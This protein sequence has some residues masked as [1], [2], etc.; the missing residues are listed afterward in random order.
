MALRA[1]AQVVSEWRWRRGAPALAVARCYLAGA[2]REDGSVWALGGGSSLWQHAATYKSTEVLLPHDHD[3]SDGRSDG[4]PNGESSSGEGAAAA[5][6]DDDGDGEAWETDDDD[7]DDNSDYDV[8]STASATG[9]GHGGS[10]S[11]GLACAR[12]WR[13]GPD[14]TVA[15]CGHG[16]AVAHAHGGALYAVGGY[17]GGLNYHA[18]TEVGATWSI[19]L[20]NA[21]LGD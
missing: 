11:G 19:D 18:S 9:G 13:P 2:C 6:D 4:S 16:A 17:G 5:D 1:R 3:G 10:S 21:S 12:A 8:G 14:M 7:S 15:R 20:A